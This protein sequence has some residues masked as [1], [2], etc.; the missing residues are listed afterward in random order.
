MGVRLI[1]TRTDG[2]RD[3][4]LATELDGTTY[5]LRLRWNE[6]E[7]AWFMDVGDDAGNPIRTSIK[8]VVGWPLTARFADSALPPGQLY[9]I[10]TSGADAEPG[11][12]E[13]GARVVLAYQEKS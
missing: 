2:T 8:V 3:Y 10:D 5:T 1:P 9:A 13:L 12:Q 4:Q 7:G 11:L 6:R